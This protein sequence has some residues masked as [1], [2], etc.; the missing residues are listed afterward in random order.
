MIRIWFNHWFRTAYSL[1]ELVK[2]HGGVYVIGSHSQEF[3][4]IRIVCDEWYTEEYLPE[5]EY[6]EYCLR[7]CR[8][9]S[10]DVFIPHRHMTGIA[11]N[12][13]R[14]NETG[15]KVLS[16][17]FELLSLFENKARAY[18]L[19]KGSCV[20]VPEYRTVCNIDE[21]KDAYATLSDCYESLCVKFVKDEG[22]QSFRRIV[23]NIDPF[24][25]LHRYTG[26]KISE[27]ELFSALA[28]RESFEDLM[29]M[30]YLDGIE[31]SVDC[32]RTDGGLIAL[33]RF[34][35][36]AR[37]ERLRF[38][39]CILDMT[40]KVLEL[41]DLQYPCDVQFKYLGD[42]P[43]L[44]EVN[45]RMSGGLP[46]SCAASGINVPSLALSKLC[47]K[48]CPMPHYLREEKIFSNVE[49]PVMISPEH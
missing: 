3:S 30:P 38:D 6:V 37:I 18:A 1:V 36:A 15:V 16:D 21:F 8:E 22:A 5:E 33:P 24:D 17:S 2:Q 23:R 47:S 49:I 26:F 31:V 9:H 27:K 28:S 44:L 12:I 32:L 19:Y 29:V 25:D 20:N 34:K 4:P 41:A 43:Y 10:I 7:F 13:S 48:G 39:D 42:K 46:M 14:F 40:Q 11:K 35:G 45:A